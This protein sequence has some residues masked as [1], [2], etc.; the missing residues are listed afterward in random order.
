M[1]LDFK[2]SP[3][4]EC[5]ILSFGVIPRRM[6]FTCRRFGTLCSI[7]IGRVNKKIR[8]VHTAYEDGTDRMFP[9]R[10]H[11][12]FRRRGITQNIGYN[13]FV[14]DCFKICFLFACHSGS[15]TCRISH[16]N[17][18]RNSS[19]SFHGI[20]FYSNYVHGFCDFTYSVMEEGK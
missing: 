10:R 13:I 6:N 12:K 15:P 16:V 18:M 7:F 19:S 17:Y 9:K 3:F 20:N 14:I 4:C 11:V 5:C 8:H 2:L 1:T